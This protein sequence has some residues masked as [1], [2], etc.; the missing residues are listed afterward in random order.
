MK[1]F[2]T[3]Y[4]KTAV[5][6]VL[7]M[8]F[9]GYLIGQTKKELEQKKAQIEHE[10]SL[11]N[12][13]IENNRKDKE[14]ILDLYLSLQRKIQK[15]GQYIKTLKKEISLTEHRIKKNKDI[16]QSLN[17]DLQQVSNDYNVL[18]Q[19]AY[20]EK[21]INGKYSFLLASNNLND[22]FVRW[23]YIKQFEAYRQRQSSVI[24]STKKVLEK[25]K[26]K[27]LN[28]NQEKKQLLKSQGLQRSK[29]SK[30]LAYR[31]ELFKILK[32]NEDGLNKSLEEKQKA[33]RQLKFAIED[34]IK[35][36]LDAEGKTK[37]SLSATISEDFA[38]A[39]RKLSWPVIDGFVIGFFGQQSHPSLEKVQITNNGIDIKP[40]QDYKVR[41]SFEGEVVGKFTLPGNK[42]TLLI[43]HGEF[44]TVYSNLETIYFE[45]GD[46]VSTLQT[47]GEL[48]KEG[49]SKLHFEI[50][51]QKVRLNPL[52][53]LHP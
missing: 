15:R 32:E 53:W 29:L 1:S 20:R 45:R 33:S 6:L 46:L 36:E 22:A 43:K 14:N 52:D 37:E 8:L 50:W 9:N 19:N 16:I 49:N 31:N 39:K 40:S 4:S 27:L 35:S 13:L 11:T 41:A 21:L 12:K 44:F 30:E 5:I 2:S 17:Y 24:L 42:R 34:L 18:L 28:L 38:R 47:I 26:E 51:R 10:I 48:A 3:F 25:R 7:A 23:R